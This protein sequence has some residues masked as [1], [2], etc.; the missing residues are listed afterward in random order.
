[1]PRVLK[2]TGDL[3]RHLAEGV[4]TFIA[5]CQ[6]ATLHRVADQVVRSAGCGFGVGQYADFCLC[7]T[8]DDL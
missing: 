8:L 3:A 5:E 4:P 2:G 6:L 1:M 7:I